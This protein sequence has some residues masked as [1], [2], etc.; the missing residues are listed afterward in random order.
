MKNKTSQ[1]A[2]DPTSTS[3]GIALVQHYWNNDSTKVWTA[4]ELEE[5]AGDTSSIR[6]LL[7][8]GHQPFPG[9]HDY[10]CDTF[11]VRGGA[12]FRIFCHAPSFFAPRHYGPAAPT[13]TIEG[14]PPGI[15][16]AVGG[17]AADNGG[18]DAIW[19]RLQVESAPLY[20]AHEAGFGI[21]SGHPVAGISH[22][23]RGPACPKR[24]PWLSW[25]AYSPALHDNQLHFPDDDHPM[26]WIANE[27]LSGLAVANAT[28]K[29]RKGA[30]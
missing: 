11:T 17:V 2:T 12:L 20:A 8:S 18:A 26:L 9:W 19:Q 4:R 5:A 14:L 6:P 29:T 13:T 7:E 16:Y 21:L 27:W 15:L 24:L 25:M 1:K 23:R 10:T 28:S 22:A 3:V 30:A